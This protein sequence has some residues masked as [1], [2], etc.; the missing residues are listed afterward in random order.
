MSYFLCH[1]GHI[2]CMKKRTVC[3]TPWCVQR[4]YSSCSLVLTKPKP[5]CGLSHKREC[6]LQCC[7]FCRYIRQVTPKTSHVACTQPNLQDQRFES[8]FMY[9]SL[10]AFCASLWQSVSRVRPM[11]FLG[12]LARGI[13]N[14]INRKCLT[15]KVSAMHFMHVWN[16][17]H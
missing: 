12:P 6:S 8:D 13:F 5:T 3:I 7:C 9:L 10:A 11:H 2:V 17:I 15:T 14:Y 1:N 4:T 16:C